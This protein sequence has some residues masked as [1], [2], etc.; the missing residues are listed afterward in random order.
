VSALDEQWNREQTVRIGIRLGPGAKL[1]SN[2][3]MQDRFESTFGI[4]IGKDPLAHP[5]AIE[6]T[7]GIEDI[8]AERGDDLG[9]R[10]LPG[11]HQFARDHI[12]IEYTHAVVFE[13]R[14]RC[15]F[16]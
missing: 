12:G 3:R 16:A 15:T 14:T 6:S 8:V 9:Q 1:E 4:R 5:P 10:R 2:A 13:P 11:H 7:F